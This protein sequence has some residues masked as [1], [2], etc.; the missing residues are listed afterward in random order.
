MIIAFPCYCNCRYVRYITFPV[1]FG[2][3][4]SFLKYTRARPHARA[5]APTRAHARTHARTG[6]PASTHAY[7]CARV[8]VLA[9]VHVDPPYVRACAR[10]CPR[11]ERSSPPWRTRDFLLCRCRIPGFPKDTSG[12]QTERARKVKGNPAWKKSGVSERGCFLFYRYVV[13]RAYACARVCVHARQIKDDP[14]SWK[15]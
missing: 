6:A 7:A 5:R 3:L 11:V 1:P 15:S 14:A 8:R 4:K 12:N 9:Y 2:C 10:M 13:A